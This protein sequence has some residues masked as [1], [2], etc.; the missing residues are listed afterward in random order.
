MM[1][2]Q[3]TA[4]G[5]DRAMSRASFD[6]P[7]KPR[8]RLAENIAR[9]LVQD[10]GLDV[11]IPVR[12][13]VEG[14]LGYQVV[15]TELEDWLSAQADHSHQVIL[16]NSNHPRHRQRFSIAHELGHHYLG[17]VKELLGPLEGSYQQIRDRQEQEADAFAAEFLMPAG[18][19]KT[20]FSQ[21][22][23]V[24]QMTLRFDV[25]QEALW[26]RLRG[27]RLL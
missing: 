21:G 2:T 6:E 25:S 24:A 12:Q 11:P 10:N 7:T 13:F 1:F 18:T 9:K 27:L 20:L 14:T 3:R 8:F 5:G 16:V 19:V 4:V 23:T 26:H 22:L 15:E 17:H